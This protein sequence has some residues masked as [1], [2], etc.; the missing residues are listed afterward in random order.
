MSHLNMHR[1][2][3]H[4]PDHYFLSVAARRLQGRVFLN[5]QGNSL[6]SFALDGEKS[7]TKLIE[8]TLVF[9]FKRSY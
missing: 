1:F 7:S 5:K 9:F 6:R 4:T 8:V 2:L 3:L